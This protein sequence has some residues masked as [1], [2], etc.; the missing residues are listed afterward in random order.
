MLFPATPNEYQPNFRIDPNT[1][2]I[3]VLAMLDREEIETITLQIQVG[4]L[5]FFFSLRKQTFT[6]TVCPNNKW[7]IRQIR[8]CPHGV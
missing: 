8:S 4:F 1:G 3:S 6:N 5:N 7:N 2:I